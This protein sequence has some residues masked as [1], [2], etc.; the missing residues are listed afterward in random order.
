MLANNS[1][2]KKSSSG[3]NATS[4]FNINFNGKTINV[5][6]I[7]S[8]I[9]AA[10]NTSELPGYFSVMIAATDNSKIDATIAW[11]NKVNLSTAIGTYKLYGI[12]ALS[13][14]NITSITDISDGGKVYSSY[15]D[16]TSS[17]ITVTASN[18]TE[19]KGT[20][21]LLLTYNGVNYPATGDFDYRY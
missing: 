4:T 14:T 20:F 19:V 9:V 11:G 3:S 10:T 5:T 7:S 12:G 18:S 8:T 13:P 17:S 6:S 15:Q 21:N 1:C 2:T 16:S